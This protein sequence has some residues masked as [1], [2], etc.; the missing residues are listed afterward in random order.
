MPHPSRSLTARRVGDHN[1]PPSWPRPSALSASSP[2]RPL[3]SELAV[4]LALFHRISLSRGTRSA[5]SPKPNFPNDLASKRFWRGYPAPSAI[6]KLERKDT[7][8][9]TICAHHTDLHSIS[10]KGL[11]LRPPRTQLPS[12][13]QS[14][15]MTSYRLGE[16]ETSKPEFQAPHPPR[17]AWKTNCCSRCHSRR[18]SCVWTR[19][20]RVSQV[21]PL[22]PGDRYGTPSANPEKPRHRRL[23]KGCRVEAWGFSPTNKANRSQGALAPAPPLR[24]LRLPQPV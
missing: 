24:R 2:P 21:S 13:P 23:L 1:T 3:R 17:K 5:P 4:A 15:L 20:I 16:T 8:V 10:A 6:L 11:Y 18:E 9:E 7:L 12:R 14:F 22:R 19:T